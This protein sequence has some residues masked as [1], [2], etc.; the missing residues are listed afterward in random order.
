MQAHLSIQFMPAP[1]P[2]DHDI[3]EAKL[4]KQVLGGS[5]EAFRQ[6]I[7]RYEKLVC[8]IVFRMIDQRE[9]R[10]DICQEVFINVYDKLSSFRFQSKLSTWIG[11]IAFNRSVNFLK[12]KRHLLIEDIYRPAGDDQD[13][14][15]QDE[16]MELKDLHPL[17]DEK[18]LNKE[19]ALLLS[20]ALKKLS[21]VQR[22]ITQLFHQQGF[23]LDEIT[24]ITG[25]PGNTVKSHL[26]R[27]RKILKD[28]VLKNYQYGKD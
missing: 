7:G 12:K 24:S 14:P 17:P 6:L 27:S 13:L 23:S 25:L 28:E 11:H 18:L 2:P 20:E 9:D 8:S 19:R 22:T 16:N 5:N 26:F 21:P 3:E 4:V 10:E 1:F 15:M